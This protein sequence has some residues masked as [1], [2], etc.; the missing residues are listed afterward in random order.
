MRAGMPECKYLKMALPPSAAMYDVH[1]CLIAVAPPG[2]LCAIV[3][4][5][6][7]VSKSAAASAFRKVH[8]M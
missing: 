8:G 4:L 6:S 1:A 2:V 7:V 3:P 5:S